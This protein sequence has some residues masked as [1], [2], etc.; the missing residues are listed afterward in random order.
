M[1]KTYVTP[2][3]NVVLMQVS[4]ILSSSTGSFHTEQAGTGS[5]GNGVNFGR[6]NDGDD[7]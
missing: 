1:K 4:N 2:N 7:W 6:G 3:S 5:S